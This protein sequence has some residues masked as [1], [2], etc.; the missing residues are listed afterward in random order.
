MHSPHVESLVN[1]NESTSNYLRLRC[2]VEC[3]VYRAA[4]SLSLISHIYKEDDHLEIKSALSL[5]E[6]ELT[7]AS[8]FRNFLNCVIT[9]TDKLEILASCSFVD[10]ET[11]LVQKLCALQKSMNCI[12]VLILKAHKPLAHW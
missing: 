4:I 11:N 10:Y 7:P 1:E 8:I 6:S 5:T 9:F 3:V 2:C 12:S